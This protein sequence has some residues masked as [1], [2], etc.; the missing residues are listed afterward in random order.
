[1]T[2]I[3]KSQLP[4]IIHLNEDGWKA[5]IQLRIM[6]AMINQR[7]TNKKEIMTKF[8]ELYEEVYGGKALSKQNLDKEEC[9]I[10]EIIK[11]YTG[12]VSPE[13]YITNN[14]LRASKDPA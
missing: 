2:K 4:N 6:I 1:M 13:N 11:R 9:Q 7:R 3:V 14:L 12:H 10:E 5:N 8:Y